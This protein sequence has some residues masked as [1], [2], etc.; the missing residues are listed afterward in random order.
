VVAVVGLTWRKSSYCQAGECAEV[1]YDPD[2][3]DVL[4]RNSTRPEVV[5][6]LPR[7]DLDAIARAAADGKLDRV[8]AGL[9]RRGVKA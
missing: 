7:G 4:I 2:T 9:D 5:V 1:A 6:R 8:L 3:G